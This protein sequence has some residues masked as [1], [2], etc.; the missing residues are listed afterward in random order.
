MDIIVTTPKK[1]MEN[2]ALEAKTVKEEG[3]G[4]YFR[5]LSSWPKKL[6]AS[7][8]IFYVE[9]G[10]VRGFC[11]IKSVECGGKI[12][13]LT[14]RNWIGAVSIIMDAQKWQWIKP[15]PMKGFQGWR[16]Y[17]PPVDMMIV[18]GWLDPKPGEE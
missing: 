16:Y 11:P 10:Y 12:C 17:E 7:S 6:N 13:E 3:H 1:E 5:S 18:G 4:Y 14:N 9:D 15:I 8:R 2:A